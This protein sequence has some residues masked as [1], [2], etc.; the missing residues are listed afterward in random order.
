MDFIFYTICMHE[1]FK[2]TH[3]SPSDS[4]LEGTS[5][6]LIAETATGFHCL[7]LCEI[8]CRRD[9][10]VDLCGS[11]TV[12]IEAYLHRKW[13]CFVQNNKF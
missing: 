3:T 10:F 8:T 6:A 2:P 5:N 13:C 7:F 1:I 9:C 12:V 11:S 4:S